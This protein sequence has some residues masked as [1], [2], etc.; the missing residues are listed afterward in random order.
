MSFWKNYTF[1]WLPQFNVIL[2]RCCTVDYT[3]I[4]KREG[5]GWNPQNETLKHSIWTWKLTLSKS[6]MS[7]RISFVTKTKT[8][9]HNATLI[10]V[11]NGKEIY[12]SIIQTRSGDFREYHLEA[13]SP[14]RELFL[15]IPAKYHI[16]VLFGKF[17]SENLR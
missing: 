14:L 4:R 17:C 9:W 6:L 15:Y 12:F 7:K 8:L 16:I 11:L 1:W 3:W 2:V 13:Q 5:I 10:N